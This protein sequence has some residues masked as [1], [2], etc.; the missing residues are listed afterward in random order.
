MSLRNR[1]IRSKEDSEQVSRLET[2]LGK[3]ILR[4]CPPCVL[5]MMFGAAISNPRFELPLKDLLVV[6]TSIPVFLLGTLIIFK[7]IRF[8][9]KK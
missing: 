9:I 1:F 2:I 3:K 7:M 8:K 4:L 5:L 6:L